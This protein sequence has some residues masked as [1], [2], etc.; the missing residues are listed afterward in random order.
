MFAGEFGG[1][2]G[3]QKNRAA[4]ADGAAGGGT[5]WRRSE[6]AE[7]GGGYESTAS[8]IGRHTVQFIPSRVRVS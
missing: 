5:G 7:R 1:I 4:Q 8:G 2:V 3:L 6:H